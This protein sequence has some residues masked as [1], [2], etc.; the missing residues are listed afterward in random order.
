MFFAILILVYTTFSMYCYICRN[1]MIRSG[2]TNIYECKGFMYSESQGRC[3]QDHH[4][5]GWDSVM[6]N[7]F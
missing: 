6:K 5:L 1:D 2:Y 3:G 4:Q 7:R